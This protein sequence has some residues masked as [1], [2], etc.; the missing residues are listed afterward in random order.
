[1]QGFKTYAVAAL[2]VAYA[3]YGYFFAPAPYHI[4][5]NTALDIVFAAGGVSA[6]R[7]GIKTEIAK[8]A[9]VFGITPQQLSAMEANFA[10]AIP[11]IATAAATAAKRAA[12]S[13][14]TALF[15]VMLI[16]PMVS[17]CGTTQGQTVADLEISYTAAAK[18]ATVAI[19]SGLLDTAT[20]QT[21]KNYNDKIDTLGA[22][23]QHHGLIVDARN[24][25]MS[26]NS[27]LLAVALSALQAAIAD[28]TAYEAAHNLH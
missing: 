17:A 24:A 9:N 10:A 14:V 6:L 8:L 4:D 15:C 16:G 21:L 11:K 3:A 25:A 27:A 18:V 26:G 12:P 1:M 23:G 19:N 22:D 7:S 2:A 13:I 28:L 20:I 5:L